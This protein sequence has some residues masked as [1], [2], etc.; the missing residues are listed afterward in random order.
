MIMTIDA[1][2]RTTQ[3][4]TLLFMSHEQIAAELGGD[5]NAS[6]AA[7]ML[8]HAKDMRDSVQAT[9][10]MQEEALRRHEADQIS[11]M[12]EE[13]HRTRAAGRMEGIGLMA[14]GGFQIASGVAAIRGS[15]LQ[16]GELTP[17]ARG[18]QAGLEGAGRLAQGTGNLLAADEKHEAD[19]ANTDAAAAGHRAEAVTRRLDDLRDEAADARELAKTAIEFLRD[20]TRTR[21]STDHAAASIRG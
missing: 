2:N 17:S 3:P 20:Q 14:S 7:M 10:S 11:A 15:T 4:S 19:N 1:T 21:A 12:H 8:L 9:R 13:A 6:V 18:N 5:V 16:G